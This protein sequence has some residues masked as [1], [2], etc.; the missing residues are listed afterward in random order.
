MTAKPPTPS[1]AVEMLRRALVLA[2]AALHRG[3]PACAMDDCRYEAALLHTR[4]LSPEPC[5][6]CAERKP[7][8]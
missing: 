5:A 2:H 1:A 7:T 4:T 6:R 8:P 3:V